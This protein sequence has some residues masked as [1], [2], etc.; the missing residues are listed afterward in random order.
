MADEKRR[1]EKLYTHKAS[2]K[3]R[4]ED[5]PKPKKQEA[6]EVKKTDDTGQAAGAGAKGSEKAPSPAETLQ[7]IRDRQKKEHEEAHG[8]HSK[9][10]DEMMKRHS[11]EIDVALEKHGSHL[12][13]GPGVTSEEA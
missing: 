11:D 6:A 3:A 5:R 1:S 12:E 10:L 2:A 13:A 9:L 7:A 8:S 4:S